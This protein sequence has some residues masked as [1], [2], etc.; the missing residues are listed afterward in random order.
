[1]KRILQNS[2]LF[3]DMD[4][5]EFEDAISA[6]KPTVKSFQKGEIIY[7]PTNFEQKIGIVASGRCTVEKMK[8]QGEDVTLN[9]LSESDSFGIVSVLCEKEEYPTRI[10]AKNT[11]E[12]IFISREDF[13]YLL[14]SFHKISQNVIKFLAK[15]IMFLNDKIS[16]FSAYNVEQKLSNYL[17]QLCEK[18]KSRSVIFSRTSCARAINAGRASLYRALDALKEKSIIT[19]DDKKIVIEDLEGLER[20]SK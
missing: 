2:F 20:N 14:Q 9:V 16:T 12:I 6:I 8:S 19:I 15:K 13:E 4:D 5:A 3:Y 10:I 1:M 7:S 18:S 17:L 11:C